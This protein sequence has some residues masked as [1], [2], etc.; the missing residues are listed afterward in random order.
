M[1]VKVVAKRQ[2]PADARAYAEQKLLRLQRHASLHDVTLTVSRDNGLVPEAAAE[3]VIHLHRLRLAASCRAA[4]VREAIDGVIDR[5]GA[6]VR[7]RQ[8]RVSSRKR[9]VG[10]AALSPRS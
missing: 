2:V 1:Q 7:R 4:N 9:R 5:A 3:V 10:A 8:E 6:Q